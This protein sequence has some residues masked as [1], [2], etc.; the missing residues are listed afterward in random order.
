MLGLI[1]KDLL[2][3]KGTIKFIGIFAIVYSIV[4]IME[5]DLDGVAFIP[6]LVCIMMM[7]TFSY[8]EF[9]KTDAYVTTFPCGKKNVVKA[10]Y[11]ATIILFIAST[12]ISVIL[13]SAIGIIN[14]EFTFQ[15]SLEIALGIAIGVSIFQCLFYPVIYKFG[16]EKSRIGIFVLVFAIVGIGALIAKSGINIDFLQNIE[17]FL[18]NYGTFIIPIV[19][20][21][22]WCISY[23]ISAH[24]YTKKEF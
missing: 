16:I 9:N 11:I 4:A 1:K 2:M 15:Y 12:L 10:K 14:G 22:I 13:S 21:V 18:D 17:A 3:I 8:D 24:I 19:T 7:T 20:I 6:V 23:C 5:G